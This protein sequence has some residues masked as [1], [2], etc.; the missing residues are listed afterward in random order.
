VG[1]ERWERAETYLARRGGRAVFFGRFVGVL[2]AMVPT[3]AGLTRMP[4]RTFLPWNVAG[5]LVWGPGFVL[6]GYVAGGSYHQV[7]SWAG[8]ASAVLFAVA[9]VVVGLLVGGRAVSR[10]EGAVRT[11]ARNQ[12]DRPALVR[13]RTRYDR[14]LAYVGRRLRPNA[15]FGL[16]LTVGLV[17]VALTGWAF[18]VVVDDVISRKDLAGVDGGVYRFFLDHRAPYL[19][20]ASRVAGYLGGTAL[21]SLVTV[22]GAV[23][24]WWRTRKLRD[25]LLPALA[26]LGSAVLVEVIRVVVSRPRPPAA[27]MLS[28]AS[29]FGFPSGEA[30]RAAACLL[31][32]AFTVCGLLPSWRAKVATVTATVTVVVLV[33][34][35]RLALGVSWFTDVLGG[36]ALGTLWFTAVVVVTQVTESRHHREPADHPAA[37]VA[38]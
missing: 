24:L 26:V 31:A 19:T 15:A 36:W 5:A 9:A 20:T 1:E 10:R 21:L 16:S 2:R 28:A 27:E 11:W 12:A 6:L 33:G 8:R 32:L 22:A 17:A 4:Y 38:P 25:L 34:V 3:L 23:V 30:T 29:G 37:K 18:G 14:Q 35:A 13:L 7:A